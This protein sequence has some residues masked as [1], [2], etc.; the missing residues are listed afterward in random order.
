M[1]TPNHTEATTLLL[2]KTLSAITNARFEVAGRELRELFHTFSLVEE[3]VGLLESGK[4][5]VVA[6]V[7]ADTEA[8]EEGGDD[9]AVAS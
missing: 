8:D 4:A 1:T 6:V 9:G 2:R 7:P 3:L 5:E